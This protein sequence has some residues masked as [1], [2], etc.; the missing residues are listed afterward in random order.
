MPIPAV[1]SNSQSTIRHSPILLPVLTALAALAASAS[2]GEEP[3][4]PED[5]VLREDKADHLPPAE[6]VE[7]YEALRKSLVGAK[8]SGTDAA[9]DRLARKFDLAAARA[10]P[11]E[12]TAA[13]RLAF[14]RQAAAIGEIYVRGNDPDR[15]LAWERICADIEPRN[16]WASVLRNQVHDWFQARVKAE[17]AAAH[18]KEAREVIAEWRQRM[19]GDDPLARGIEDY[20]VTRAEAL[21][22]EMR[23][24][25]AEQALRALKEEERFFPKHGRSAWEKVYA[26]AGAELQRPFDAAIQ[27]QSTEGAEAALA[28]QKRVAA[29][30]GLTS[31]GPVIEQNRQT[32]E[33]MKKAREPKPLERRFGQ[34]RSP[35]LRIE[36]GGIFGNVKFSESG[37]SASATGIIPAFS[38]DLRFHGEDR[39]WWYGGYMG[40]EWL[41]AGQGVVDAT[42]LAG[43]VEGLVGYR[44]D[45]WSAWT[46][47]GVGMINVSF[48]GS[49]KKYD[50]FSVILGDLRVGGEYAVADSVTAFGEFSCGGFGDV[51]MVQGRAGARYWL[52]HNSALGLHTDVFD[53]RF[54]DPSK[55]VDI[56]ASS[57]GVGASLLFQF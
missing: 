56:H 54:K 38:L 26:A 20:A 47:V 31:L 46:G 51:T 45:R 40:G 35:L 9:I 22:T 18:W 8:Y 30:F 3:P 23:A 2:A 24:K 39:D 11:G 13:E 7:K 1:F 21:L 16:Q 34:V 49:V 36:A 41:H 52:S 32:L 48:T 55:A 33:K 17:L 27:G 4:M 50:G 19:E 14:C 15:A 25:G 42:A 5:L 29:E 37:E 44:G 43:E 12:R 10:A 28:V 6:Q 57:F 53:L